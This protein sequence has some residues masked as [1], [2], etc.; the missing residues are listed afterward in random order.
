M[1]WFLL[2]AIVLAAVVLVV[3]GFVFRS[4]RARDLLRTL[5]NAALIYIA[6]VFA[7]GMYRFWQQGF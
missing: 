6:L 2:Q 5:R 3:M 4:Q 7:L 1:R